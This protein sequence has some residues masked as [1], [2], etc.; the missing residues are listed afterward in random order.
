MAKKKVVNKVI[1]MDSGKFNLKAIDS[2][3]KSLIFKNK[4]IKGRHMDLGL[5]KTNSYNVIYKDEDYVVGDA[6][7]YS[8]SQEGKGSFE[9]KL[10]TLTAI[11]HFLDKEENGQEIV[12]IYGESVNKY[13][14]EK[15]KEEIKSMFEGKHNIIVDDVE[16]NFVVKKVHVLLEG[17]GC[18]F[19]DEDKYEGLQYVVDIGGKTIN[20][21]SA[22][23]LSPIETECASYGLG[24]NNIKSKVLENAK[25]SSVD[26]PNQLIEQFILKG[27][28]TKK[29]QELIDNEI[30]DQLNLFDSFLGDKGIN[31]HSILDVY[32]ITFCGGG[33]EVFKSY[34]KKHYG[35][36][37]NF[38]EDAVNSN[39][40]GFYIYGDSVYG[41]EE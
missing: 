33:S 19:E 27:A 13:Y 15:N 16:Y 4:I 24:V 29:V 2:S 17:L 26:I 39:V 37:A 30:E 25:K 36:N 32:P 28:S 22:N 9:H 6:G 14:D 21:V 11:T 40:K 7:T 1:A 23:N 34:L 3:D 5:N 8:D 31:I 20:F 12:L 41:E 10:T 35:E 18:I 38:V